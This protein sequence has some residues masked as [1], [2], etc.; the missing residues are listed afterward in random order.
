MN[1]YHV[2][3]EKRPKFF[4][5]RCYLISSMWIYSAVCSAASLSSAREAL[6][7]SCFVGSL[8]VGV[9]ERK[10]IRSNEQQLLIRKT[11]PHS[12]INV[13]SLVR[14][15]SNVYYIVIWLIQPIASL[16]VV[17]KTT[18]TMSLKQDISCIAMVKSVTSVRWREVERRRIKTWKNRGDIP[19]MA[20]Q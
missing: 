16:R 3:S 9:R 19:S 20:R 12:R 18:T 15:I 6:F 17:L 4:L 2:R 10:R 5:L 7:R 14:Y 11:F 8:R 13:H 1:L